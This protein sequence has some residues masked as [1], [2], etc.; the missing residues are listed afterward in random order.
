[1]A[2]TSTTWLGG[3]RLVPMSAMGDDL[4]HRSGSFWPQSGHSAGPTSLR[5]GLGDIGRGRQLRRPLVRQLGIVLSFEGFPQL[6]S[7]RQ[8]GPATQLHRSRLVRISHSSGIVQLSCGISRSAFFARD[9][10]DG[11]THFVAQRISWC[12]SVSPCNHMRRRGSRIV[13]S[14]NTDLTHAVYTSVQGAM[15]P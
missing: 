11:D 12:W 2:R 3:L 15:K 6:R 13:N 4:A 10:T 1:M 7:S 9:A 5:R 8:R 14:V